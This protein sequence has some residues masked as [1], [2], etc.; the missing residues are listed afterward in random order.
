MNMLDNVKNKSI[1][2]QSARETYIPPGCYFCTYNQ[3]Y[4][5]KKE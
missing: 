3:I 2:G 4:M 1:P 5:E